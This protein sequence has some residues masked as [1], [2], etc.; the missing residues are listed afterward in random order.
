MTL[1]GSILVGSE[2]RV[3][4]GLAAKSVEWQLCMGPRAPALS[5]P[6]EWPGAWLLAKANFDEPLEKL[7]YVETTGMFA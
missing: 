4:E 6:V 2:W 1:W 3:L 7:V 5:A